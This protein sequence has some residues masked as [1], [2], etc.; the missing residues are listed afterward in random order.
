[1]QNDCKKYLHIAQFKIKIR[2]KK[3]KIT[4][5]S[6]KITHNI[7]KKKKRSKNE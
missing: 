1:M 3:N 4:L 6:L 5:Q 7:S 2:E